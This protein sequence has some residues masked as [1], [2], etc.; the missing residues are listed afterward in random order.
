MFMSKRK[1]VPVE[2]PVIKRVKEHSIQSN[3]M[4]ECIRLVNLLFEPS[5]AFGLY[6]ALFGIFR[7]SPQERL[8]R[9]WIR[10]L[11]EQH[12]EFRV[13]LQREECLIDH[14]CSRDEMI[15]IFYV[16]ILQRPKMFTF[17]LRV[18]VEPEELFGA[19][20]PMM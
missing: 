1:L 5:M 10:E 6:K 4:N 16:T 13:D 17:Y 20:A 2:R 14:K 19:P 3:L 7:E 12:A 18:D 15:E 11:M 8:E 9:Q